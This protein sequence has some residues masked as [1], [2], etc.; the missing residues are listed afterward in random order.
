MQALSSPL[1]RTWDSL[2][3]LLEGLIP[4]KREY[5][6][7]SSRFYDIPIHTYKEEEDPF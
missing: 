3:Y 2:F 4:S 1:A 6:F 7:D 5:G